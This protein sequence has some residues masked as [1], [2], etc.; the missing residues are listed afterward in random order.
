MSSKPVNSDDIVGD[1]HYDICEGQKRKIVV[2]T[3]RFPSG[4]YMFVKHFKKTTEVGEWSKIQQ[5]GLTEAEFRTLILTNE[6][7]FSTPKKTYVLNILICF[8]HD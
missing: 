4:K 2:S 3:K 8:S 1:L 5:I 7:E 6:K